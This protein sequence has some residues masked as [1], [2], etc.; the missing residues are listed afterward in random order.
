MCDSVMHVG[1]VLGV[2]PFSSLN[3]S[4]GIDGGKHYMGTI[5]SIWR[6]QL[7]IIDLATN[8]HSRYA[9]GIQEC[10]KWY[11]LRKL[12]LNLKNWIIFG[13]SNWL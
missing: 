1:Y 10:V 4:L 11:F 9:N 7:K 13:V 8:G 5:I 3:S 6:L 2:D 12:P